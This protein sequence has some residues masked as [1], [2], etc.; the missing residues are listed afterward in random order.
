MDDQETE[1]LPNRSAAIDNRPTPAAATPAVAGYDVLERIDEGGMGVVWRAVQLS[2]RREVALKFMSAPA[3]MT[4][5]A[6]A[7][8]EREVELTASLEHPN[9]ARVYDS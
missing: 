4:S 1:S 2:T 7:R 9:I 5:R 6:R 8:F 3:S